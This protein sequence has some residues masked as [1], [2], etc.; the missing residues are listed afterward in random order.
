MSVVKQFACRENH[1]EFHHKCPLSCS[2][3]TS[4][5]TVSSVSRRMVPPHWPWLI[6]CHVFPWFSAWPS[7]TD[8]SLE[9]WEWT[10][11]AL[12]T[13]AVTSSSLPY[14]PPLWPFHSTLGGFTMDWQRPGE[15][16]AVVNYGPSQNMVN[17]PGFL[18]Q[19]ERHGNYNF[20]Q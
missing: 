3:N 4:I 6:V 20:S 9:L 12:L 11:A 14:C 5:I 19:T 17:M 16:A 10:L 13:G 2:H 1:T 7:E 18:M 8:S 15:E